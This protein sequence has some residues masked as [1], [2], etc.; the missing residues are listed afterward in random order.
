MSE[1]QHS[2]YSASQFEADMLC[3]GRRVMQR[4]KERKANVYAAAGTIMHGVHEQLLLTSDSAAKFI[5]TKHQADGFDITFDDEMADI[6]D[7][8][9]AHMRE[10]VAGAD[11]VG[12]ERRVHYGDFIGV[13]NAKAWGTADVVALRLAQREAFIG[14]LKTGRDPV[15]PDSPQLK[16]YA[17]GVVRE[18]EDFADIE[19]VRMVIT[20]PKDQRAPKE[21]VI[22]VS[23]LKDWLAGPAT[24]A[25]RSIQAAEQTYREGDEE[26]H[27]TFLQPAEKAC[28]WCAAKATCPALRDE[29]VASVCGATPSS[30]DEFVDIQP[31]AVL[32]DDPAKWLAASLA[33]V[34]L[35]EDWCKAVRAEVERRLLAGEPVPGYKL[36]AGKRGARQWSDEQAAEQLLKSF[37]LKQEELYQMKLITPAAADKLVKAG[38]IG[39]RQAPKLQALIVQKDGAP[40]V[41]P[42]SDKR[43]PLVIRPVADDF[44]TL[45]ANA[46]DLC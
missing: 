4:G 18:Y 15:D 1:A 38:V 41:A 5:G 27:R 23:E 8:S 28:K 19:T 14:D 46:D 9:L 12:V 6:V 24:R 20:Q 26:W 30:P 29:V 11:E 17:A 36:V 32:A 34:D 43:E 33:K 35:I 16:L 39:P 7:V 44:E 10:Y 45:S 13:D 31:V 37:R 21:H 22:K 42:L 40:H 3:P 25:V 2:E